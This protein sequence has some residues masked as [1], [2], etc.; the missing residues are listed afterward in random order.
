M[1][2]TF[3]RIGL[4][5]KEYEIEFGTHG[6]FEVEQNLKNPATFFQAKTKAIRYY[7]EMIHRRRIN[8]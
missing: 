2:P 1:I 5:K 4:N 8:K 3:T 6:K 7:A